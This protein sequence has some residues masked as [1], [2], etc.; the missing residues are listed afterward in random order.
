MEASYGPPAPLPPNAPTALV[1]PQQ[2]AE[3][4]CETAGETS[5]GLHEAANPRFSKPTGGPTHLPDTSAAAE[6]GRQELKGSAVARPVPSHRSA[7]IDK[8]PAAKRGGLETIV[9]SPGREAAVADEDASE[10]VA[11]QELEDSMEWQNAVGK[12]PCEE[13]GIAGR[14]LLCYSQLKLGVLPQIC[15]TLQ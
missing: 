1:P 3:L 9:E 7:A 2:E 14:S 11:A 12:N 10:R 13:T 15:V 8:K 6:E 4:E 5:K